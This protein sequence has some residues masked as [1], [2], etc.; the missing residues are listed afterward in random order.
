[1]TR[2]NN[3]PNIRPL[4]HLSKN[5]SVSLP[6][7]KKLYAVHTCEV[8][9]V[10]HLKRIMGIISFQFWAS[11]AYLVDKSCYS[12]KTGHKLNY[13]PSSLRSNVSETSSVFVREYVFKEKWGSFLFFKI[14]YPPDRPAQ[15]RRHSLVMKAPNACGGSYIP[16][17]QNPMIFFFR[18]FETYKK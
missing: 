7:S 5:E 4:R 13:F 14:N 6:S 12:T 1:M 10:C 15:L 18:N 16:G 9:K 3:L 8:N 11:W 17:A 2:Q